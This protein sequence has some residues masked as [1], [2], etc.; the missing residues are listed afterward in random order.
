MTLSVSL[1]VCVRERNVYMYVVVAVLCCMSLCACYDVLH[2]PKGEQGCQGEPG[3]QG[4]TGYVVCDLFSVVC[5]CA[6]V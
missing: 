2:R 4:N 3:E 5:V 1:R 6:C